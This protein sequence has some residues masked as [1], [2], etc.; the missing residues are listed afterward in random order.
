M[1]DMSK[2]INSLRLRFS[3]FVTFY[4][5]CRSSLNDG[6]ANLESYSCKFTAISSHSV[7][8]QSTEAKL[9]KEL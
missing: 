2:G 6:M 8:R 9:N 1:R 5:F 7:T 4:I 3:E